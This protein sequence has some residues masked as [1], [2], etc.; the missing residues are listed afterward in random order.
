ME[1]EMAKKCIR[2]GKDLIY[3]TMVLM[4]GP[5]GFR[6]YPVCDPC[7]AKIDKIPN[8]QAQYIA[9]L[10]PPCGSAASPRFEEHKT[11][12]Q[13]EGGEHVQVG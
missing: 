8:E 10:Q 6:R 5:R 9:P 11:G 3:F 12:G 7:K 4:M 13:N 2:C 1:A